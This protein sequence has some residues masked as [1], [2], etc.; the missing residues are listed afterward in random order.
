MQ[1][2]EHDQQRAGFR[3]SLEE[4]GGR[5]VKSETPEIGFLG[6]DRCTHSFACL[7]GVLRLPRDTENCHRIQN[8]VRFAIADAFAQHFFPR[9]IGRRISRF[10]ASSPQHAHP[11]SPR[12]IGYFVRDSGLADTGLAADQEYL[13]VPLQ[14]RRKS[15]D[16]FLAFMGTANERCRGRAHEK[17]LLAAEL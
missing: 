13:S 2:I 12:D 4:P 15:R 17:F 5:L 14:S 3:S 8:R 1:I 10:P 11:A 7:T 16:Q 9:P 6:G